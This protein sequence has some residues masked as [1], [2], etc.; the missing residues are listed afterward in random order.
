[1]LESVIRLWSSV[2]KRIL[3]NSFEDIIRSARFELGEMFDPDDYPE[4]ILDKYSFE[5]AITVIPQKTDFRVDCAFDETQK[6]KKEKNG[7]EVKYEIYY[8]PHSPPA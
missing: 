4:T 8:K 6:I 5:T 1:M 2:S 7:E 3:E